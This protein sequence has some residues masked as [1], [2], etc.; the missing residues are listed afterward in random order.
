M[1]IYSWCVGKFTRKIWIG[2]CVWWRRRWPTRSTVRRPTAADGPSSRT[3]STFFVVLFVVCRQ[4]NCLTTTS[5]GCSDDMVMEFKP[6]VFCGN[7][8]FLQ[9]P[10]GTQWG[11]A[12]RERHTQD[13]WYWVAA[14]CSF[15]AASQFLMGAL[16]NKVSSSLNPIPTICS[17]FKNVYRSFQPPHFYFL[18]WHTKLTTR[19]DVYAFTL[20]MFGDVEYSVLA[21]PTISNAKRME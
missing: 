13:N 6:F 18:T 3:T 20:P 1:K 5:T 8:V 15:Q 9:F 4:T 19:H 12:D 7:T 14:L 2:G 17:P 11:S 21:T 10:L 16:Y